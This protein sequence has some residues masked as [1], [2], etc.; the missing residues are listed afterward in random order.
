MASASS[1][2]PRA[3][4]P[5]YKRALPPPRTRVA[6]GLSGTRWCGQ[7]SAT[8]RRDAGHGVP[9]VFWE[10]LNRSDLFPGGWL[11]DV[12]LPMT[13]PVEAEV[14]KS[15]LGE[16]R[17]ILVQAF[18]RTILAHDPLS[19]PERRVERAN[20]GRGYLAAFPERITLLE[21]GIA[22]R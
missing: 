8:L 14:D 21:V 6:A 17:R 11:H 3:S 18:Q 7:Y 9:A 2:A 20:V 1:A 16:K 12:G 4:R 13:E 5:G 10:Y 19:P 22:G 15:L